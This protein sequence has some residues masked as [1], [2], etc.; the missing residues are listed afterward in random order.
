MTRS[1]DRNLLLGILAL[2]MDFITRDALIQ[3]M[4]A[5]VFDKTRPLGQ[6]MHDQGHLSH[7]RLQLLDALVAE[8]VRAHQDDAQQS[9]AS[10]SSISSIKQVLEALPDPELHASLGM[11]GSQ[12]ASHDSLKTV[13]DVKQAGQRYRVLRP[14]AR[15]GLGEISVAEDLELP[16]EVALKEIQLHHAD[17][18]HSRGR[19]VLEAEITGG[20]EHPGIVPVY[21]L[22]TYADGRPFYAMRFIQGDNLKDAIQRF[23]AADTASRDPGSRGLELRQ[24]LGRFVDVCQ[25]VAYAHSRGV[26]HRDLK[27]GNI[28]LGKYGETLVV[29][30]GL[31]KAVGRALT[32][33][34]GDE[35]TLKPSSGS[36]VAATQAGSALGTPAYMSPEQAAGRLED[37]GPASDV[38]SLG[39]TL[40][41][42][43]T[44][45]APFHKEKD[46]GETLRQ[47]RAGKFPKPREVRKEIPPALEAICLKAMALHEKDRYATALLLATDVEH[48]LADEPVGVYREPW[49]KQAKRWLKRHPA[50][51]A[52]GLVAL[53]AFF[54]MTALVVLLTETKRLEL[55]RE[56][57][58]KEMQR[59]RAVETRDDARTIL[60]LVFS[61]VQLEILEKQPNLTQSQQNPLKSL[62]AYYQRLVE[63]IPTD[64]KE[65]SRQAWAYEGIAYMQNKLGYSVEA[66]PAYRKSSELYGKLGTDFPTQPDYRRRGARS[67][68]NLSHLQ[69]RLG[70]RSEAEMTQQQALELR[71][72]L[73][74]DFPTVATYRKELANSHSTIGHL[75]LTAGKH[76]EGADQYRLAQALC[77]KLATDYPSTSEYQMDLANT[78]AALGHLHADLGRWPEAEAEYARTLEIKRKMVAMQPNNQSRRHS[79]VYSLSGRGRVLQEQ[80][81]WAEAR[82]VLTEA[83]QV[84]E[85]LIAQFPAKSDFRYLL[86]ACLSNLGAIADELG[87]KEQSGIHYRRAVELQEKVAFE[88]VGIPEQ[89]RMLATCLSNLST[90]Q[91]KMEDFAEAQR[92]LQRSVVLLEALVG[93]FPRELLYAR[94]LGEAY[95]TFGHLMSTSRRHTDSIDWYA[96]AIRMANHVLSMQPSYAN[97]RQVRGISYQGLGQAWEELGQHQRA[98]RAWQTALRGD[99]HQ[100]TEARLGHARALVRAGKPAQAVAVAAEL[101]NAP[102]V[103]NQVTLECTRVFSLASAS[104]KGNDKDRENCIVDPENWTT[105]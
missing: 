93:E 100:A 54:V 7:E 27:P 46:V 28:M 17:D 90:Y 83:V 70:M 40:Y 32:E 41:A 57:D 77:A 105:S 24:L 38:Y 31:A 76:E 22:G 21:G 49:R 103:T 72:G 35:R 89:R 66:I 11:V 13:D 47:V 25:A 14:H 85:E 48:W 69:Q 1:S 52:A 55:T 15:G 98:E 18:P 79:F 44:G 95:R 104:A 62:L 81:R 80:K 61:E 96:R 65:R 74:A 20:L 99:K 51:S 23:H 87:Q 92:T 53:L 30:W 59:V 102:G 82:E 64:Q 60:E 94:D 9:L 71:Q 56:R 4:N 39:A 37:L 26:L 36:Q 2:Q 8:H 50:L 84:L 78:H 73:V 75:L 34:G 88:S 5:W 10:L 42:L 67:L 97:A 45:R 16:R 86:A 63:E 43:L 91:R 3:A 19:F 33:R 12:S 58:E 68:N 29:D 6:I 101:S